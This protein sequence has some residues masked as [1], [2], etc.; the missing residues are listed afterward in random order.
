MTTTSRGD[1]T[2]LISIDEEKRKSRYH[3]MVSVAIICIFIIFLT[4][5]GHDLIYLAVNEDN[6]STQPSSG[7]VVM[8]VGKSTEESMDTERIKST[9]TTTS[10]P[11]TISSPSEVTANILVIT[12]Y[13]SGS[14]FL[15]EIFNQ[16][17]QVIYLFEPLI[18]IG[19]AQEKN[20]ATRLKILSDFYQN[21]EIPQLNKILSDENIQSQAG[22]FCYA[23]NQTAD[24]C[25]KA[26]EIRFTNRVKLY[27]NCHKT[28]LCFRH[29]SEMLSEQPFCPT[30]KLHA[31]RDYNKLARRYQ[32]WKT[33]PKPC[34]RLSNK[35]FRQECQNTESYKF[36]AVKAIRILSLEELEMHDFYKNTENL[37]IIF[38]LR[39]PRAVAN[40]RVQI[41]SLSKSPD[42][43]D[44]LEENCS[45]ISNNLKY[46]KEHYTQKKT[47]AKN[48]DDDKKWL[49][50]DNLLVIRYEDFALN[51]EQFLPVLFNFV[52]LPFDENFNQMKIW[53]DKHTRKRKK[54]RIENP[55]GSFGTTRDAHEVVSKWKRSLNWNLISLMQSSCGKDVYDSYGYKWYEEPSEL[56]QKVNESS[57]LP[58]WHISYV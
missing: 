18:V 5:T 20:A 32:T 27:S 56:A 45:K 58:D 51:N 6:F 38:L 12:D 34:P 48:G 2:K 53:L 13:R 3:Y 39:D 42:F 54:R 35:I 23:V 55:H 15:S 24:Y 50:N 52:N 41:H 25:E 44:R 8:S 28:G 1:Y 36:R 33:K 16:H 14:T 46:I 37:K 57:F 40:S 11:V 21:C 29:K 10:K 31:Y 4:S 26:S 22:E 43:Y 17:P 9:T 19:R 49:N 47:N 30:N 7:A